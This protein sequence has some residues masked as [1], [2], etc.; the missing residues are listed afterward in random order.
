MCSKGKD[1]IEGLPVTF[2]VLREKFL[3]KLVNKN[4]SSKNYTTAMYCE[5]KRNFCLFLCVYAV[6]RGASDVRPNQTTLLD[7]PIQSRDRQTNRRTD[8]QKS[9]H[10]CA[11][12]L[13]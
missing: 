10:S 12:Q 7:P 3:Q 5:R 8:E 13:R 9:R 2:F 6:I 4:W 11:M 1:L